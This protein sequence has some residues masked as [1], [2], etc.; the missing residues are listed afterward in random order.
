MVSRRSFMAGVPA[1]YLGS[2]HALGAPLAG[3]VGFLAGDPAPLP[4]STR[5]GNFYYLAPNGIAFI[6]DD[7]A[8]FVINPGG[9]HTAGTVAPDDSFHRVIFMPKTAKPN[10]RRVEFQWSRRGDVIV[11]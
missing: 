5:I 2:R 11:G 6:K 1:A 4:S 10:G 9:A 7:A 8:A 3:A